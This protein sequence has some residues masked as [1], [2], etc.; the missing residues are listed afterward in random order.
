MPWLH[1]RGSA[2][3]ATALCDRIAAWL[4]LTNELAEDVMSYRDLPADMKDRFAAALAP[5]DGLRD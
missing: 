1:R 5:M 3:R 4:G 2:R